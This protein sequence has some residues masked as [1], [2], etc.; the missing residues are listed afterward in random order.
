MSALWAFLSDPAHQATLAWLGGGLVT[1]AGGLWT[2]VTYLRPRPAAAPAPATRSPAPLALLGLGL[3]ALV[4][5]FLLAG[6]R[7]EVGTG[8]V[9]PGTIERSTITIQGAPR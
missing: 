9:N 2:V 1:L 3:L 6:D 7:Q 4:A 8:I 5:A